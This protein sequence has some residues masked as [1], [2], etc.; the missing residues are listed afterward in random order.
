M[1]RY[2]EKQLMDVIDSS[3]STL[4]AIERSRAAIHDVIRSHPE[5]A[6]AQREVVEALEKFVNALNTGSW[7]G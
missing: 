2:Q 5:V 1:N 6:L 7:Y 4:D 3:L